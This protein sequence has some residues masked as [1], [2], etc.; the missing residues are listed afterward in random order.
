VNPELAGIRGRHIGARHRK[1]KAR[2]EMTVKQAA[3][4]VFCD[5][6]PENRDKSVTT[7]N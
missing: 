1:V 3:K 7:H 5:W 6:F 4:R 2:R